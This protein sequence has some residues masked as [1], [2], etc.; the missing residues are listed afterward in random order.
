VP[1]WIL[2]LLDGT[3]NKAIE[4]MKLVSGELL[5]AHLIGCSKIF[6]LLRSP[7]HS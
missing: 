6:E 1:L 4:M 3:E 7:V 5:A 2:A